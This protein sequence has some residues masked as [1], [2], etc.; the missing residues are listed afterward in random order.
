MPIVSPPIVG[1]P[2]LDSWMYQVTQLINTQLGPAVDSP[3]VTEQNFTNNFKGKIEGVESFADVT[4]ASNVAAAGALMDSEVVN[5]ADVKA[6]DPADYATADDGGKAKNALLRTGGNMTGAI[7]T[8][9]TFD[10][11][12]V[13]TDGAKLDGVELLAD[14]TDTV[15]V[16]A[17]GALMDSEVVNLA[18][19]KAFD[20]TDY[21]PAAQGGVYVQ[22]AQPTSTNP[23]LWVQTNVNTAGDFSFWFTE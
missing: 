3:S 22:D 1:D 2:N 9:S 5:L 12:D 21:A 23:Y 18:A 10:G 14:V 19:V 13:A 6:F 16:T 20:P 7:T 15:N 17:A 11:R 8:N 4:D